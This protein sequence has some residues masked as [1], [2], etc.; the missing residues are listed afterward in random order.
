MTKL[1]DEYN[2]HLISIVVPVHTE[3]KENI[4]ICFKEIFVLKLVTLHRIIH[5]KYQKKM[6][7][8]KPE[9]IQSNYSYSILLI[10][11]FN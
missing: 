9:E 7:G 5:K 8:G 11:D 4:L 2:F 6:K 3:K 10:M 1:A